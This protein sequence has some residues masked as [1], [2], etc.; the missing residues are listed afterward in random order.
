MTAENMIEIYITRLI[1]YCIIK[2]QI[3]SS[4]CDREKTQSTPSLGLG[5]EFESIDVTAMPRNLKIQAHK[6]SC[7]SSLLSQLDAL[8]W[9][10]ATILS[11]LKIWMWRLTPRTGPRGELKKSGRRSVN[12][13]RCEQVQVHEPAV[14]QRF[15]PDIIRTSFKISSKELTLSVNT[16]I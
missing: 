7:T 11:N 14:H 9:G 1:Q 4:C 2:L 13:Y 10:K 6:Y 15:C 16:H 5:L 12:R 3:S 8:W